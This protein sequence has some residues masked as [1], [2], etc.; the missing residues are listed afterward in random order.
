MTALTAL[1]L[2]YFSVVVDSVRSDVVTQL[3]RRHDNKQC[4]E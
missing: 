4:D 2:I 3:Q 1:W